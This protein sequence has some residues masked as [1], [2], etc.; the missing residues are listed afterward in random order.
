MLDAT[1]P[2]VAEFVFKVPLNSDNLMTL[3]RVSSCHALQRGRVVCSEVAAT[4]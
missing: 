1:W 2:V 3:L 4:V